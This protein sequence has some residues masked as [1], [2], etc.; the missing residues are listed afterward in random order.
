MPER[1]RSPLS[2]RLALAFV[3]VAV[4]AV[5]LL[6]ALAL[7]ATNRQI[8]GLAVTEQHSTTRVVQMALA[9]A[10]RGA[11]GWTGADFTTAA[12]LAAA[13]GASLEVIDRHG[14]VVLGPTTAASSAMMAMMG[15]SPGA[16]V[17]LGAPTRVSVRR[18]RVRVGEALLRFP[19]LGLSQAQRQ[20]RSSLQ[21]T[22]VVGA[23]LAVLAA[24]IASW[25]VSRRIT[26]PLLELTAT[27]RA[28][29][30]GQRD[31]RTG[32]GDA[33]GEIGDLAAAFDRMA[34]A[35]SDEDA[36]RRQQLADVAHELRTPLTILQASLEQ[37]VDL[38]AAASVEQIG[39]LSDEVHRLGRLV[40][41]LETLA[42]AE[43]ARLHL[44][45]E[46]TDLAAVAAGAARLLRPFFE[47]ADVTLATDLGAA[48]VVGDPARLAQVVTNL[49]TNA[50]KF[51]RSG[52]EVV[53]ATGLTGTLA[54][55]EVR[56]HGIGISPAELPHVF[57]RFWRSDAARRTS[58]SGIGLA[59]VAGLVRAHQGQVDVSSSA[60][61]G[62][63]FRVSLPAR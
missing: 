12:S 10:Y 47:G 14:T 56:D 30:G 60:H 28:I 18:G 23:A 25:L 46:P 16:P 41:D 61:G 43:A 39:S 38:G 17:R 53:V 21:G 57:E 5:G 58:G 7:L 44:V 13:D 1:R 4:V 35:L 8:S 59:V 27:V 42:A 19:A 33:P 6:A 22:V 63:V 24:L 29:E 48:P 40:D 11:H 54:W 20:V 37:M 49:L 2:A 36:L 52:E 62:T 32:Q 51:S 26:R 34:G 15:A 55:L 3:A 31:A 50:L 45:S 9:E